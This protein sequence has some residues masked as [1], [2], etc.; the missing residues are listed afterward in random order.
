M[1]PEQVT[2]K[3]GLRI[4]FHETDMMW[5]F[6]FDAGVTEIVELLCHPIDFITKHCSDVPV[7]LKSFVVG[8]PLHF[9]FFYGTDPYEWGTSST[10]PRSPSFTVVGM[11]G[12]NNIQV[13]CPDIVMTPIKG[14][15]LEDI[16]S[17]L[18][19][20][21]AGDTKNKNVFSPELLINSM[22]ETKSIVV[23]YDM[24]LAIADKT[25]DYANSRENTVADI[26]A[27][28]INNPYVLPFAL[29]TVDKNHRKAF[30][31]NNEVISDPL[32][33]L[34]FTI[35]GAGE[36]KT[37]AGFHFTY[38]TR[39]LDSAG[40]IIEPTPKTKKTPTTQNTTSLMASDC[41]MTN[42]D[43]SGNIMGAGQMRW[44]PSP[45]PPPP[46]PKPTPKPNPKS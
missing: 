32:V 28:C 15:S 22:L 7:T 26:T 8:Q 3:K 44:V 9:S 39:P 13:Y 45:P 2:P 40:K 17:V 10:D 46:A 31:L 38:Q 20:F 37:L 18:R 30:I 1:M 34:N 35:G 21:L 11:H 43:P 27:R 41:L 25:G 19:T 23:H 16:S 24:K 5:I 6:R 42:L 4:S 33:D 14:G 36:K 12:S 29:N